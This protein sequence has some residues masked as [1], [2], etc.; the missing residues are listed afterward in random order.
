MTKLEKQRKEYQSWGR[1]YYHMALDSLGDRNL[2]NDRDEYVNGM[3]V[4]AIGQFINKIG[5][6]QFDWMRNH[7][8]FILLA[9][10]LECC[11]FFDYIRFRLNARLVKD[12]FSP[13][14]DKWFFKLLR[15]GSLNEL[16][17]AVSYSARN[18]YDARRDIL[19][20]GYL[21]SSNYVMFSDVKEIID[22]KTVGEIGTCDMIRLLGSKVK[23]PEAYKV[24]KL[25]FILPESYLLKTDDGVMTKACSLYK[26][27]KD[28]TYRIFRDYDTYK[29]TASEL[30]EAWSPSGSDVDSLIEN[31]LNVNYGVKDLRDLDAGKKCDL[32]VTLGIGYGLRVEEIAPRLH[33]SSSMVS[34]LLYSY[35]K[36]NK[37]PF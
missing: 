19:P 20:G 29:R 23:L 35:S 17:N 1:W 12:G 36:K 28:Y 37:K 11:R 2:F 13:L 26:D 4:V 5:V 22:Y 6:I 25:G 24:C 16:V 14:P 33:L 27:S 30:G 9:T 34:K 18:S 15:L 31:I 7:G 3:N 21:W 10:G 8:H 32:A